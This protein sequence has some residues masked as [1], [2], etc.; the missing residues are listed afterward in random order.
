MN[1]CI[2]DKCQIVIALEEHIVTYMQSLHFFN[3]C[4]VAHNRYSINVE[5][6]E[7]RREGTGKESE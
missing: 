5:G 6:R 4:Q 7:G 1:E 2:H 3:T